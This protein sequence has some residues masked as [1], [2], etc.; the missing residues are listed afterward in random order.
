MVF[1]Q[2][3]I[4]DSRL[5]LL[6]DP[7]DLPNRYPFLEEALCEYPPEGFSSDLTVTV[8]PA[9]PFTGQPSRSAFTR[10]STRVRR[11]FVVPLI[12]FS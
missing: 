11:L 2:V 8:R 7:P 6:A 9:P 12:L 1:R 4:S 3:G 5:F 10:D